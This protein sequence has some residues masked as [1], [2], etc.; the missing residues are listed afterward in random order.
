MY[1]CV[2]VQLTCTY[3]YMYNK[4]IGVCTCTHACTKFSFKLIYN[5][6]VLEQLTWT[7][8][9][10]V[11]IYVVHVQ[12]IMYMYMCTCTS[13]FLMSTYG[14]PLAQRAFYLAQL[15]SLF[16][17]VAHMIMIIL[18]LTALKS[19]VIGSRC[20]PNGTHTTIVELIWP[21]LQKVSKLWCTCTYMYSQ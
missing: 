13:V 19:L 3:R 1:M 21:M 14:T 6:Y 20:I 10:H 16:G 15:S 8:T 5:V 2:L 4:Y 9:I 17:P 18:S 12:C 11:N 7:S